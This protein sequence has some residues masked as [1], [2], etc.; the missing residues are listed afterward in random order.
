M[1]KRAGSQCLS[2]MLQKIDIEGCHMSSLKKIGSLFLILLCG[3]ATAEQH[4]F[5]GVRFDIPNP[6][7]LCKSGNSYAEKK[8]FSWQ[9]DGQAR[10]GSK[11]LGLWMD[12][13]SQSILSKGEPKE[14]EEWMLVV[15]PKVASEKDLLLRGVSDKEFNAFV[16]KEMKKIDVSDEMADID[17][18]ILNINKKHFLD[19]DIIKVGGP[20]DLGLL[21]VGDAVHT[22]ML[23]KVQAKTVGTRLVLV[24]SSQLLVKGVWVTFYNYINYQSREDVKNLLLSARLFAAKLKSVN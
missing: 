9:E 13:A 11:L 2:L 5:G 19:K 23:M 24:V 18:I 10:N 3:V 12:C 1:Q 7:H 6:S 21:H 15:V 20:V 22:G 8:L 4:Y 14:L 17:N 16:S